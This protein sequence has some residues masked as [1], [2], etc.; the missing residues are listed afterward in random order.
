MAKYLTLQDLAE[1][2][3]IS[4]NTA[5]ELPIPYTR[6]GKR[7]QRRYRLEMVERSRMSDEELQACLDAAKRL[8]P[9]GGRE[10]DK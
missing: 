1:R 6:I 9:V 8:F 5:K 10:R 3:N 7:K 2:L 4:L